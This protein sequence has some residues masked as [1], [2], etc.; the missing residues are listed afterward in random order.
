MG[1]T[2]S[3]TILFLVLYL[4]LSTGVR[5]MIHTCGESTTTTMMPLSTRAACGCD[6]TNGE[7]SCC[8]TEFK[9]FKLEDAQNARAIVQIDK[10]STE[11]TCNIAIDQSLPIQHISTIPV[12]FKYSPH[13]A[14]STNILNCMF[15]M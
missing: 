1:M 8:K 15:L 5:V 4:L 6:D 2:K 7:D 13:P 9:L 12:E 11:Q 3:F 14:V 10:C